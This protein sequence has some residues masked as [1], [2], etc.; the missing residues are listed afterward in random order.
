MSP[1]VMYGS[2]RCEYILRLSRGKV[3]HIYIYIYI[4]ICVCVCV[5]TMIHNAHLWVLQSL[6]A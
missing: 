4:Y 6:H 3:L 5:C 1:H 2:A